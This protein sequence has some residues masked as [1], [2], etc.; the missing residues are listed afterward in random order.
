MGLVLVAEPWAIWAVWAEAGVCR[1]ADFGVG[2]QVVV[3]VVCRLG[4]VSVRVLRS[5]VR[6]GVLV[7]L[8]R[9]VTVCI[10]FGVRVR[11]ILWVGQDKKTL[12]KACSQVANGGQWPLV[13]EVP[14]TCFVCVVAEPPPYK[15]LV[16]RVHVVSVATRVG[17]RVGKMPLPSAFSKRFFVAA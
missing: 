16:A 17:A 15:A 1:V 7:R 10:W 11:W 14:V 6:G 13:V 4:P 9:C 5:L 12:R 8:A 3:W 2:R